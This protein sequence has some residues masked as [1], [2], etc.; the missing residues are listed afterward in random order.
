[1]EHTSYLIHPL[2][3]F[4]EEMGCTDAY[5]SAVKILSVGLPTQDYW[6]LDIR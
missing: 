2:L 3:P 4:G 1:M 5:G 6:L